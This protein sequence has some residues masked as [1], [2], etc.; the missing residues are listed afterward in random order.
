MLKNL[1][2]RVLEAMYNYHYHMAN[3]CYE[4][5]DRY[6]REQ[7]AKWEERTCKHTDKEMKLVEKLVQL[8]ETKF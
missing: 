6:G 5:V 4:H 2:K 1:R 3:Y 7:N 8:E